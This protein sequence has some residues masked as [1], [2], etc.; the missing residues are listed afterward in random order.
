MNMFS[1]MLRK[2]SAGA[3]GQPTISPIA[4]AVKDEV[5]RSMASG[6]RSQ[7]IAAVVSE[8]HVAGL[9]DEKAAAELY[10]GLLLFEPADLSEWSTLAAIYADVL[11]VF[12]DK[13]YNCERNWD[14]SEDDYLNTLSV[15]T[16]LAPKLFLG[17]RRAT[18]FLTPLVERAV[19]TGK[20]K[21]INAVGELVDAGY[22][23]QAEHATLLH[24]DLAKWFRASGL[25][26]T[27]IAA[28]GD[29]DDLTGRLM[30]ERR[31][32]IQPAPEPLGEAIEAVF[33]SEVQFFQLAKGHCPKVDA[34]IDAPP[35]ER[36]AAL[37]YLLDVVMDGDK[38][39]SFQHLG[40]KNGRW[41][42]DCGMHDGP[43]VFLDA[44]AAFI[45]RFTHTL[46]DRD[47]VHAKLA[48]LLHAKE[49]HAYYAPYRTTL[50][51]L[52]KTVKAYPQGQTV[53]A[54]RQL[55]QMAAFAGWRDPLEQALGEVSAPGAAPAL[56]PI[57]LPLWK[58]GEY[59]ATENF[60]AHYANL[61][62]PRLY[63]DPHDAFIAKMIELYRA[64][65]SAQEAGADEEALMD[66]FEAELSRL[67]LPSGFDRENIC[68]WHEAVS[69]VSLASHLYLYR[70]TLRPLAEE[71][72]EVMKGLGALTAKLS[73]GAAPSASWMKAAKAVFERL[74]AQDWL[75]HVQAITAHEAPT[76]TQ[77]GVYG[78][79]QIRTLLYIASFLPASEIGP[80]LV[81]YALKRCYVTD[82]GIGMRSEKLGNACVWALARLPDA[83]G[84][85]YLARVLART[86]Y[87]KIRKRIDKD[88]NEAAKKAGIS[89]ADLDEATVPTHDL[90]RDGKRSVPFENGSVTLVAQGG[91][92]RI[93]WANADGQSVKAPTKAMKQEK[94]LIKQVR[95]ELKELQADLSIQPQRLQRLYL[96]NRRWS[97]DQWRERYS[98]HPLLR[99][100]AR[101]LIWWVEREGH[102]SV[103][104]LPDAQG[105]TLCTLN[106]EPVALEGALISLWHP[107]HSDVATIKA[108]RERL[109]ALAITQPFAQAFREV[110]A[111]TDAER[112]SAT[113]TNRWAA[114]I[115]KQHQAMTLA[116]VN[117]W[118]VTARMWVDQPNNEPWHLYMP[119]RNLVAEY[120]VEGA[121]GDDPE[122]TESLAYSYI[123]T[124]RV[125]FFRAPEGA[126]DSAQGP[127]TGDPLA[128][129]QIPP[130]VFSEVMR[131]CDLLTAVA[132][133]AA[134][135]QWL[136]RGGEAAHPNQWDR[137]ADRYWREANTADLVAS[138]QN[139]RAMLERIIPRLAI[140]DQLTLDD[141][142]LIVQGTRHTYRI[143]LGSGA[144]SRDGR[145]ICIVPKTASA[146]N[147][148]WLPFEG[149]RTLSIILSKAV[150]LAADDK[151]TDPVILAQF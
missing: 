125:T 81:R 115:L 58:I 117:G 109:E 73:K 9:S 24:D 104:A 51:E 138:G 4:H 92:A 120:W 50:R 42:H 121:G 87:P 111:L 61:F 147:Q 88:L 11:A 32:I 17:G 118:T 52:L 70:E 127:A 102:A 14:L 110:Y 5:G 37:G 85:P 144:C 84:I 100:F 128:L 83:E 46:E 139:R 2:V 57:E 94:D 33:E 78:E 31:A 72:R 75:K 55:V 137:D 12:T 106:G 29:R 149:D 77:F 74:P 44:L 36:G 98:E 7:D 101:R 119:E 148:V 69:L 23:S 151:I 16:A 13:L 97:V 40:R 30:D 20:P 131:T 63:C 41:A 8:R 28:L 129:D 26:R 114:H 113:Y 89:R 90:D 145:H 146:K 34:V 66:R 64:L 143:H 150:M 82:P 96:Q 10:T 80:V 130:I 35:A 60:T 136:D 103:A 54:M 43:M 105:D 91:Q 21:L 135:D 93:E 123:N 141:N 3:F 116:R 107:L 99:G 112:Q 19:A 122:T 71:H 18:W 133:I 140:A 79:A 142:S 27:A 49:G 134:D 65:Y 108:W 126:N 132:S 47:A 22:R 45:A 86:K 53:A 15:A 6:M 59:R 68:C 39:R 62:E 124:D 48:K 1:S 38:V 56:Q 67:D 25:P 76:R 95:A